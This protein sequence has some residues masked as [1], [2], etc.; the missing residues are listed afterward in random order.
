MEMGSEFVEVT[1]WE[2]WCWLFLVLVIGAFVVLA[3]SLTIWPYFHHIRDSVGS[4]KVDEKYAD[5][6]TFA[7][8]FFDIEKWKYF[9]FQ[10][11]F[12]M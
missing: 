11:L 2:N 1:R 4:D 10:V 6:L 9:F 12:V 5:A 7:A 8:N 3:A